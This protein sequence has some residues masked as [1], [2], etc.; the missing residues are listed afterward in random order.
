MVK[1]HGA[2]SIEH[3]VGPLPAAFGRI[4][5]S[6]ELDHEHHEFIYCILWQEGIHPWAPS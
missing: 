6:Q 3:S 5:T 4:R 1:G 2:W